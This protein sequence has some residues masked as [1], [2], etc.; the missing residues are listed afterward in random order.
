MKIH[1]E[2]NLI[3]NSSSELFVITRKEYESE[4][5]KEARD[6]FRHSIHD[7]K[8]LSVFDIEKTEDFLM[9]LALDYNSWHREYETKA[10]KFLTDKGLDYH[11]CRSVVSEILEGCNGEA[12]ASYTALKDAAKGEEKVSINFCDEGVRGHHIFGWVEQLRDIASREGNRYVN[13]H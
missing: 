1:S 3:T 2:V 8:F 11:N 5:P 13:N 6:Y 4:M 10:E 12:A 9:I 7:M